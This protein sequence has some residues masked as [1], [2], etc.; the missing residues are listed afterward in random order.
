MGAVCAQARA[1]GGE[2]RARPRGMVLTK[3]A[4]RVVLDPRCCPGHS[5]EVGRNG[6]T[7]D[8]AGDRTGPRTPVHAYR[9]SEPAPLDSLDSLSGRRWLLHHSF[10]CWA[11]AR[12]LPEPCGEVSRRG[13]GPLQPLRAHPT[14][15]RSKGRQKPQAPALQMLTPG[16][17]RID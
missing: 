13:P 8:C 12:H 5:Q 6:S 17:G 14:E 1:A 7:R 4:P 15:D 2:G 9:L 16:A 11:C 3:A 10:R